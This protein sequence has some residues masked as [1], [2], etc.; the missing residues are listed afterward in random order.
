MVQ[1]GIFM[2]RHAE[3][4]TDGIRALLLEYCGY[5]TKVVQFVSDMHTPKN[6][7]IIAVKSSISNT[8]K[9]EILTKISSLKAYFGIGY[10]HLERLLELGK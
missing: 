6:V 9:Q 10:H 8:R 7:M 2:E 1:Y 3:M 4:L 5:K